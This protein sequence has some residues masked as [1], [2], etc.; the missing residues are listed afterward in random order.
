MDMNKR[1]ITIRRV[2]IG[3]YLATG[4]MAAR[5]ID[6]LDCDGGITGS[7]KHMQ[8]KDLRTKIAIWH[9]INGNLKSCATITAIF[10]LIKGNYVEEFVFSE[11]KEAWEV[12]LV[13]MD[14]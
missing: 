5:C 11:Q 7:Y 4:E 14:K 2:E 13:H 12:V 10:K 6:V 1:G 8:N 9:W 3:D